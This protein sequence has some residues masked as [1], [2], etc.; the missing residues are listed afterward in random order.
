MSAITH[1]NTQTYRDTRRQTN[2]QTYR[3]A[4]GTVKEKTAD[5]STGSRFNVRSSDSSVLLGIVVRRQTT[6]SVG[7]VENV[8]TREMKFLGAVPNL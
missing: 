2:T 7:T 6:C 5:H 4:V 8:K 3:Q 1:N